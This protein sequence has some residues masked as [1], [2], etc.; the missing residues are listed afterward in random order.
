MRLYLPSMRRLH[1][2][3]FAVILLSTAAAAQL[4]QKSYTILE[5]HGQVLY[6]NGRPAGQGIQVQL[7]AG[8]GGV[9]QELQTDSTGKFSFPSISPVHYTIRAHMPGYI[10]A[11]SEDLDMSMGSS[12]YVTLTLRPDP[13]APNV[14]PEG[15]ASMIAALPADM[16]E[17]AKS[18]YS[19]GY[20]IVTSGQDVG[21]AI[22]HFQKVIA[23]YPNY[24]RTY[25]LLGTAYVQTNKNDDAITTLQ[26]AVAIDPKLTDAYTVLGTVLNA[27]KK[28]PDA[29][30]SLS[31]AVELDPASYDAQY[32][33]GRA[34]YFQQKAPEAQTHLE[35]AMKSNPNSSE[36]HIMMGNVMLRLRN[37]E[38]ALKEYQQ[39]VQLDPKGPM[40]EGA[41]QMIARIQAAL[42]AQKK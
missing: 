29:E 8:S 9:S 42:S 2:P 15:A 34:L 26:K 5:I 38:G 14:P 21:K 4:G 3:L 18:E 19:T 16:P 12:Q 35:A 39:G 32:Q 27:E 30:Q 28:F 41:R 37:A 40:S 33:L 11:M 13:N 25:L 22:P 17:S 23:A 10:D 1:E 24:A 7:L 36:A 20:N 6:Q 31:K